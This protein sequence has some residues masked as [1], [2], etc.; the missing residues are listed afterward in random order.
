[1]DRTVIKEAAAGHPRARSIRFHS[2]GGCFFRRS[3]Y[4]TAG[5]DPRR[6]GGRRSA[7][8]GW[9]VGAAAA[10]WTRRVSELPRKESKGP[11]TDQIRG[12]CSG[13]WKHLRHGLPVPP[14]TPPGRHP[15]G[16]HGSPSI[17]PWAVPATHAPPSWAPLQWRGAKD[18]GSPAAY[19]S[20]F[21]SG[22][23]AAPHPIG[24]AGL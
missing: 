9:A 24:A 2:C 14:A 10:V 4:S 15:L 7:V 8:R 3:C 18:G 1:M 11:P 21:G 13:E 23:A 12:G 16:G 20:P 5:R 22:M 19:H 6:S 17:Q